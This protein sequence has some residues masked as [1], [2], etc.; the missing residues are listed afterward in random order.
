MTPFILYQLKAGICLM[1]F[2]GL[3]YTLFRKETFHR[4]NRFYL[5]GS[6]LACCSDPC[7]S[8]AGILRWQPAFA[9][10]NH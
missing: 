1:L 8:P 5:L 10:Q 3:Y 2:T 6:L 4:F 9:G 7:R